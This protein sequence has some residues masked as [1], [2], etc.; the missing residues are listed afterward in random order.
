MAADAEAASRF[1]KR[2]HSRGGEAEGMY[3]LEGV[4]RRLARE[5][6]LVQEARHCALVAKK[7]FQSAE[8]W[9]DVSNQGRVGFHCA[10]HA[11]VSDRSLVGQ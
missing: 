10:P 5:M 11:P 3:P 8:L 7:L 9:T 4:L 1:G 6:I 2:M